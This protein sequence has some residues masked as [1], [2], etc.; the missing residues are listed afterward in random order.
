VGAS[1]GSREKNDGRSGAFAWV[2]AARKGTH[3]VLL[4]RG[5]GWE[6]MVSNYARGPIDSTRMELTGIAAGLTFAIQHYPRQPMTWYCDNDAAVG[7][8][9]NKQSGY[10]PQTPILVCISNRSHAA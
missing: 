2:I 10:E 5:W 6:D 8:M 9:T 3:L 4:H 7:E 1:D